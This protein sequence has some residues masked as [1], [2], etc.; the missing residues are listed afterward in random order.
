LSVTHV[1]I[2]AEDENTLLRTSLYDLKC[3]FSRE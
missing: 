3:H 2:Q 1:E